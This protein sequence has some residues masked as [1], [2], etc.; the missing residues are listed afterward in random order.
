L[1][2]K[3]LN[4]YPELSEEEL[5]NVSLLQEF[6][7]FLI[8]EARDLRT[9]DLLAQGTAQQYVSGVKS[10]IFGKFPNNLI[11]KNEDEWYT[12]MYDAIGK[13]LAQRCISMGVPIS[14]KSPPIERKLLKQICHVYLKS[15][16]SSAIERRCIMNVTY[17]DVGRVGE[18]SRATYNSMRWD[19]ESDCLVLDWTELKTSVEIGSDP[20]VTRGGV[21]S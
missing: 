7:T 8:T 16:R 13:G 5:C 10:H 20:T 9:G 14:Q 3:G 6:G 18:C 1:T 11:W 15:N 21:A 17:S 2:E 4:T 12:K 19:L